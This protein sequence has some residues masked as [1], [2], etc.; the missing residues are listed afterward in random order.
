MGAPDMPVDPPAVTYELTA[1][2]AAPI[3]FV[4]G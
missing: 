3:L 2:H 1:P 4:P